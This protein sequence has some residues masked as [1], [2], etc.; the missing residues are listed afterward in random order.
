VVVDPFCGGGSTLAAA[1]RLGYRAIGVERDPEY[2][3]LA[4]DAFEGLR[5]LEV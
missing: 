5:D 1:A 4:I 2:A 3:R